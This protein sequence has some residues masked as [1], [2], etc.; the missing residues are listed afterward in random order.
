MA[1]YNRVNITDVITTCSS[2][3]NVAYLA[4]SF[5]PTSLILTTIPQ[6]ADLRKLGTIP[7]SIDQGT[8]GSCYANA[9]RNSF[10]TL[11]M[12]DLQYYL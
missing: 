7:T 2:K 5:V 8:C 12:R 10:Y 3:K 4:S 11:F 1:D 9:A 6:R